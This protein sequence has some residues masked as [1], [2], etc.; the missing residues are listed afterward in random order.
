MNK[1][2]LANPLLIAGGIIFFNGVAVSVITLATQ[3][4][5]FSGVG[6]GSIITGLALSVLGLTY[7]SSN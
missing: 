4:M 1:S 7:K 5:G 2:T 3:S 6:I